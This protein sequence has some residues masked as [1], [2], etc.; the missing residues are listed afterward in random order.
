MRGL[1]VLSSAGAFRSGRRVVPR[2]AIF[3]GLCARE[4]TVLRLPRVRRASCWNHRA[5]PF[6]AWPGCAP[7]ADRVPARHP[8]CSS[9]RPSHRLRT[10]VYVQTRARGAG[11]DEPRD[12]HSRRPLSGSL[13]APPSPADLD[14]PARVGVLPQMPV[15]L[16]AL[17]SGN[18]HQVAYFRSL[19]GSLAEREP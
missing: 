5:F 18:A 1:R 7:P 17:P 15:K 13:R 12:D 8:V 6:V 11:R 4:R 16:G 19:V 3:R 9:H 14:G 10:R 2:P